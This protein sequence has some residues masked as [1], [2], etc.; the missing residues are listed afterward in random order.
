ML[1]E[2]AVHQKEISLNDLFE[3]WNGAFSYFQIKLLLA[4]LKKIKT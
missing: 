1:A 3:K 2:P 4:Y